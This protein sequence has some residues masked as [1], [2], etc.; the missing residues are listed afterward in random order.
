VDVTMFVQPL[1]AL[2][3]LFWLGMVGHGALKDTTAPALVVSTA[4]KFRCAGAQG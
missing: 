2:F 3:M 1:A 4:E